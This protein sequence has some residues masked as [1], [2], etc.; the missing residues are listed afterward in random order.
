MAS[1]LTWDK[2]NDFNLCHTL[3]STILNIIRIKS[4]QFVNGNSPDDHFH[5]YF[6]KSNRLEWIRGPFKKTCRF[7]IIWTLNSN[8]ALSFC[9]I[10][11]VHWTWKRTNS[12]CQI[13]IFQLLSL[14]NIRAPN[15]STQKYSYPLNET[16]K[17]QWFFDSE[18]SFDWVIIYFCVMKQIQPIWCF[19]WMCMG[20]SFWK[21]DYK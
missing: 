11:S 8:N 1:S 16:I 14:F 3:L 17:A 4:S 6:T 21:F 20:N 10:T 19:I 2:K 18:H 9:I 5:R 12:I 15:L 13:I 7:S